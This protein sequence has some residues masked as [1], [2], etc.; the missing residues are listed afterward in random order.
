M[1]GRRRIDPLCAA[2]WGFVPVA[3]VV[4]VVGLWTIGKLVLR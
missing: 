2:V 1:S 3:F 4:F